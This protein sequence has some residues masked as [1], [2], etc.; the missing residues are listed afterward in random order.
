M[1]HCLLRFSLCWPLFFVV[2][3]IRDVS[4]DGPSVVDRIRDLAKAIVS[5]LVRWNSLHMKK[6]S[7]KNSKLILYSWLSTFALGPSLLVL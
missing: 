3:R 6:I 2:S 5:L 1:F 7:M 4:L